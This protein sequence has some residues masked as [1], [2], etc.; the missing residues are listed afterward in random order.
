VA[1]KR[2]ELEAE[3]GEVVRVGAELPAPGAGA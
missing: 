1:A 3:F 2:D